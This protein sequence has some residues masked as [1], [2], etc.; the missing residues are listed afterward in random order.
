MTLPVAVLFDIDETLVHTGGAGARSWAW[1]FEKLHGIAADI[2]E[3]SSA[4]ETDPQ[5]GRAT[6]RGVLNRE[7]TNEEMNR[8]YSAY[9]WHLY[10]DIRASEGY[11]VFDGVD[12]LLH[13]LIDAGVILGIVS[14][15][16]EGAA[17]IKLGPGRL[18]RFFV[19]GAY[20]SDSPDRTELVR[21]AIGKAERLHGRSLARDEV[22]V[23]GDTPHDIEAAHAAGAV[24]VGVA[25]GHY[26]VDQLGSS[27]A[28]HVLA[29]LRAA[30]PGLD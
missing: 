4:G 14:G 13:R 9:L 25:T 24:G 26:D 3:H 21:A 11:R 8:L 10:D 18:E 20:G 28:E 29:D 22:F 12:D 6:F 16:M 17:R 7:P 1:A 19:F 2:G 15:A 27:G 5:V 30:F 23:V